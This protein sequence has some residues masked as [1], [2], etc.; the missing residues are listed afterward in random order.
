M[1]ERSKEAGSNSAGVSRLGSN[2]SALSPRGGG[3]SRRGN[4][5]KIWSIQE[6]C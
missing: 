4:S 3:V 5:K 2:P 6:S 1:S